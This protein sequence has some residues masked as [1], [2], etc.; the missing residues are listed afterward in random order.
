MPSRPTCHVSATIVRQVAPALVCLETTNMARCANPVFF[1][2]LVCCFVLEITGNVVYHMQQSRRLV[3]AAKQ[4]YVD[5]CSCVEASYTCSC[6][7]YMDV[8]QVGLNATACLDVRYIPKD[9]GV[10]LD[11]TLNGD[12]IFSEEVSARNPPPLCFGIPGLEKEA[13]L[14]LKLY[15]LDISSSAFSG[16]TSVVVHLARIIVETFDL[17]CFNIPIDEIENELNDVE[18]KM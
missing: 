1:V 8:P 16:C 9:V 15:N 10:A 3:T 7:I 12:V 4:H 13:R 11:F 5:G 6:C 14:C 18:N 2:V 17:G